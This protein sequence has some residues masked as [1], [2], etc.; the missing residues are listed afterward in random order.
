MCFDDD[1]NCTGRSLKMP[2]AV[3]V[4]ERKGKENET[5]NIATLVSLKDNAFLM[6]LLS[7]CF[8]F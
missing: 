3:N 5:Y 7:L 8:L 6:I 1:D 4:M 2:A